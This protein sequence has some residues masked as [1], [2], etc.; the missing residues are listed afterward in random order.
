MSKLV[1]KKQEK[2]YKAGQK[3][4]A[5]GIKKHDKIEDYESK[6]LKKHGERWPEKL[7]PLQSAKMGKLNK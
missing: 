7:T 1:K 6:M 5:S 4:I 2:E 3:K